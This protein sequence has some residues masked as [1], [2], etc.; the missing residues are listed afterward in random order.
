MLASLLPAAVVAVEAFEDDPAA[1]LFPEESALLA[2]AVDKRRREFTTARVCA[3]R[4]LR[5]LGLPPAPIL[6]GP[7]GAPSWPDGV[8]GS[9]THCAGYRAAAVARA[10]ELCTIG[11]DAE[12][13]EPNPQGVTQEITVAAERG[14]LAAHL[15]ARPAVRWDRL[16]FSAKESV[17]K[18][19]FPL[20]QRWLGFEDA[21]LVIDL[22]TAPTGPAP[23][24]PGWASVA[25]GSALPVS[26][27]PPRP[28][29][30]CDSSVTGPGLAAGASWPAAGQPASAG[31]SLPSPGL[32]APA[33]LRARGTFAARLLVDGP[34]LD[35][36]RLTGFGGHWLA[37][38]GLLVTAVTVP[39][40]DGMP[41]P[42]RP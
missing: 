19:W 27:I 10:S 5:T 14:W 7:R 17:Y 22:G 16:L 30:Q 41:M 11:I 35:G 42:S 26:P 18:A 1:V 12:P 2:K 28:L 13:N 9:I 6:P 32:P 37:E 23:T 33:P 39:H 15:A 20:A 38:G 36:R 3:H 29:R 40:L 25:P 34:I 4:A 31:P 24:P 8:V 21:E